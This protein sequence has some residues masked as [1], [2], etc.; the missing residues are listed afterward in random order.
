M[1]NILIA[2]DLDNT[3]IHS[4]KHK[5]DGDA[6]IEMLKDKEQG[7]ADPKVYDLLNELKEYAWYIPLTTRSIEQYSRIK[8][9]KGADPRY[10]VT[11]NGAVLLDN[12]TRQASWEEDSKKVVEPYRN[13]INS[14]LSG[15]EKDSEFKIKRIVDDMFAFASCMD[16]IDPKKKVSEYCGKSRLIAESTGRKIYFFPPELGKGQALRRLKKFLNPEFVIAAGD[17]MIDIPMLEEADLSFCKKDIFDEVK[18]SNKRCFENETDL[19]SSILEE[20][21]KMI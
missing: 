11:T 5:K 16:G 2:C 19:I 15:L 17:S 12:G 21:R 1:I 10:A 4:Y 7:Y 13:D 6:C 8:W 18:S 3:L 20:V 14:I 9:P